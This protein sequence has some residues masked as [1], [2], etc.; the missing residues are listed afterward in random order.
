MDNKSSTDEFLGYINSMWK[1]GEISESALIKIRAMYC[2]ENLRKEEEILDYKLQSYGKHKENV[3]INQVYSNEVFK[4][5]L[6]AETIIEPD[7]NVMQKTVNPIFDNKTKMTMNKKYD[8]NKMNSIYDNNIQRT[9]YN[10]KTKSKEEQFKETKERNI[11]IILSLG[12]VLILL[13]GII[14]ATSTWNLMSNGVK[15]SALLMV[16]IIFF[17]MSRLAEKKLKIIKT[18][19]AFWILGNLFLPVILL[20]IGFFELLGPYLSIGGEGRYIYGIISSAICLMFFAYSI[21]KYKN[22]AFTWITLIDSEIL[23]LFILKQLS[24][25][26]NMELL[27]LLLYTLILTG[28]YHIL[29]KKENIYDFVVETIKWY[30]IINIILDAFQILGSTIYFTVMNSI[31]EQNGLFKGILVIGL[32]IILASIIACW[33]NEF[34]VQGGVLVSGTLILAIHMIGVVLRTNINEFPYYIVMNVGLLAI[35]GLIYYYNN[36][37]YL[38]YIK[39]GT[40]MI[41]FG[42]MII[43][44]LLSSILLEAIY[45]AVLLYILTLVIFIT[46]RKETDSSYLVL[47][48]GAMIIAFFI[49]NLFSLIELELLGNISFR[50][51]FH[52][53]FI[54]II[55]NIGIIY[56]ISL[57]LRLKSKNDYKIYF[58][59]AHVFLGLTYF[60]TLYFQ[61]DRMIVGMVICIV[62]AICLFVAKNEYK[63][64]I[65][66][67]SLITMITIIL[68]DLEMFLHFNELE[69]FILKPENL[70]LCISLILTILWKISKEMWREKLE[71]YIIGMYSLG[72]LSS[73]TL[74]NFEKLDYILICFLIGCMGVM[75]IFLNKTKMKILMFVPIA[76]FWI[77]NLRII[78][79]FDKINQIVAHILV[80]FIF[81]AGGNTLYKIY[82]NIST[83]EILFCNV[84]AGIS[85]MFAVMIS[86]G[87]FIPYGFNILALI[88]CGGYLYYI[89]ILVDN[90]YFKRS[91]CIGCIVFNFIAYARLIVELE[92]LESLRLEFLLVPSIVVLHFVLNHYFE[93]KNDFCAIISTIWYSI[94]GIILLFLH[95]ENSASHAII[96]CGLCIVS[97]IIGF[98]IRNKIYF[99]G[100]AVFLIIGVFLNTLSFWLNIPWWIYLLV[101]GTALIFFASKNEFN[102]GKIQDKKENVIGK[103]LKKIK[104]W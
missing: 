95:Q 48:K 16:S 11:T 8:N 80:S 63:I 14:L 12:I 7:I 104:T 52:M 68:F 90:K 31:D 66:L 99:I 70:F 87:H 61:I 21:K 88:V 69:V 44:I 57:I 19:F 4:D 42:A 32:I 86:F 35:Y 58:Y 83:K 82:K 34:K 28:V 26:Y 65:Y 50:Q 22:T 39:A 5:N 96:F 47:L 92:F 93:K 3:P 36:F 27:M 101:G 89:N 1:Q 6:E 37:K 2:K 77:M 53:D 62:V 84:F 71:L 54:Y 38:K 33:A 9:N 97:I 103:L 81:I 17:I 23:F 20:S 10:N 64:R 18:S 15:T 98:V 24:L 72:F 51:K 74:N 25:S 78:C 79:Y 13:A 49:A 56:G 55:L 29:H 59:E 73:L 40:E 30:A 100:G 75:G 94:V 60:C 41:V 85:I 45:T 67:Y 76:C 43:L 46:S 102:K 91:L